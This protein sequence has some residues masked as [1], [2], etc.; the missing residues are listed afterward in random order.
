MALA[1]VQTKSVINGFATPATPAL[2]STPTVGNL[3]IMHVHCNV[4]AASIVVNTSKWTDFKDAIV[5]TTQYGMALYRYVQAGDT[6]ALPNPWTVGTTYSAIDMFEI[7]GVSGTFATDHLSTTENALANA[8]GSLA[9]TN[10]STTTANALA[11]VG[12]GHYDG[13]S[14]PTLSSGWSLD[15]AQHN[16]GNFGSVA[17]GHQA[18]A[19]SGTSVGVTA[20]DSQANNPT[21]IF[22]TILQ[23]PAG[24]E[25]GTADMAFGGIAMSGAGT[26]AQAGTGTLHFGPLGFTA[27][28]SVLLPS[29]HAAMSF[30]GPKIF[31]FGADT[32]ISP[33]PDNPVVAD[34]SALNELQPLTWNV[35]ISDKNSGNPTPEFQ[36]KW[37]KQFDVIKKQFTINQTIVPQSYIDQSV[38]NSLNVALQAVSAA[39]IAAQAYVDGRLVPNCIVS[40]L[41]AAP[42]HG[43]RGYVTDATGPTFGSAVVGAGSVESPVYFDG[44]W[45]VG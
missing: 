15:E 18:I 42:A 38:A 24:G 45:K 27:S 35:P 39:Q 33:S 4:A 14:N 5:S 17:A 3:I 21:D 40:A 28:G 23:V 7:S 31:G 8:T 11:L 41:P 32:G 10:I 12:F 2:T 34:N 16:S 26:A 30:G 9:P 29:G 37:Q 6:T 20:T 36:R 13:N 43:T 44:T 22:L 25:T 1:V 19:S